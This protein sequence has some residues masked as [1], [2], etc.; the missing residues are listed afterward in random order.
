MQW[1]VEQEN[2][3]LCMSASP[4]LGWVERGAPR[5]SCLLPLLL[6][7]ELGPGGYLGCH[8]GEDDHTVALTILTKPWKKC[9][10]D[11]GSTFRKF[12]TYPVGHIFLTFSD[13]LKF[14]HNLNLPRHVYQYIYI[15]LI[16]Y[17]KS[18]KFLG[19]FYQS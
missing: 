10:N 19:Q 16:I 17:A 3:W 13:Y 5:W 12:I 1:N 11:K 14:K 7:A 8:V 15:F 18:W 2:L 4:I 9:L 6:E